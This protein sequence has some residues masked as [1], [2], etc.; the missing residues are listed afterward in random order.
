MLCLYVSCISSASSATSTCTS[1]ISEGISFTEPYQRFIFSPYDTYETNCQTYPVQLVCTEY[2]EQDFALI[3]TQLALDMFLA[4]CV[5][6]CG[7]EHCVGFG[8]QD[9]HCKGERQGGASEVEV[10]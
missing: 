10:E 2:H 8:G 6:A 7:K 9:R 4:D 5:E 1:P 3:N